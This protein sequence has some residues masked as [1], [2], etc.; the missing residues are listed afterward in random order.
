[1]T[2]EDHNRE[3]QL[4][5]LIDDAV[6][7][8]PGRR[9]P[10]TLQARVL[11]EVERRA[12]LPWW[13]SNFAHWPLVARAGFLVASYGFVKIA[14]AAVMRLTEALRAS[15]VAGALSPAVRLAHGSASIL[16]T[17]ADVGASVLRA[18]P[19]Y[20]LYG[21]AVTAIAFYAVLFGL[22]AAA[23]RTLYIDR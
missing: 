11:A 6:R 3:A 12:A 1:M 14:L 23:Y 10:L 5:Q 9:A 19:S 4:E 7:A 13:R 21:G 15:E 8:L 16:S 17:T 18:I 2:P 20:W 22:G